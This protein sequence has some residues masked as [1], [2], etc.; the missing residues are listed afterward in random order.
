VSAIRLAPHRFTSAPLSPAQYAIVDFDDYCRLIA[1]DWFA[2]KGSHTFY[3]ECPCYTDGVLHRIR[4]HR[5]IMKAEKG[6]VIDHKDHNGLN[7]SR[8]NLRPATRSQN[9]CNRKKRPGCTSKYIGVCIDKKSGNWQAAIMFEGNRIYLGNFDNEI[10]AALA[11][12]KAAILYHGEFASL[13]FPQV[14]AKPLAKTDPNES[15]IQNV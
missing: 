9:S 7:N 5:L 4:M 8:T 15:Q 3:A 1:F 10:D 13:N 6:K 2:L 14:A 11:Y 12:D